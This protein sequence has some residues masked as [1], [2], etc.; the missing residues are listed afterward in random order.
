M[1]R[2]KRAKVEAQAAEAAVAVEAA[3]V[4]DQVQLT[5]PKIKTNPNRKLPLKILKIVKLKKLRQNLKKFHTM[6]KKKRNRHCTQKKSL[7]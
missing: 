2:K 1:K 4:V 3:A 5:I 6:K 7:N